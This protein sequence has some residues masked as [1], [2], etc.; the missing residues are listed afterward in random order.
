MNRALG[1]AM[2]VITLVLL[3]LMIALYILIPDPAGSPMVSLVI[4][5]SLGAIILL[6]VALIGMV[7]KDPD[8]GAY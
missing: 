1:D 3:F 2:V 8:L 7:M 4:N 5:G 6:M